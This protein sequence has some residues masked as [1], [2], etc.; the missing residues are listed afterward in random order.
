MKNVMHVLMWFCAIT[1]RLTCILHIHITACKLAGQHASCSSH[2]G[3]AMWSAPGTGLLAAAY[4]PQMHRSPKNV[5]T[6]VKLGI[7]SLEKSVHSCISVVPAAQLEVM[8]NFRACS[9]WMKIHMQMYLQIC[10]L[11]LLNWMNEMKSC[12][13]P[14]TSGLHIW[15]YT[16]QCISSLIHLFYFTVIKCS[17]LISCHFLLP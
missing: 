1:C 3:L 7:M 4:K 6:K 15:S 12:S 2:V 11:N 5:S 10:V 17:C 14:I 13:G 16:H 9:Q 8:S